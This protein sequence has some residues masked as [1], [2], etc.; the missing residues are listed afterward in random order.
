MPLGIR[1]P[2]LPC[3]IFPQLSGDEQQRAKRLY[4]HPVHMFP[5]YENY[6]SYQEHDVE[7]QA[8]LQREKEAG[9]LIMN[10]TR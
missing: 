8:E 1:H 10:E 2:I 7:A 4:A 3:G 6:T 9:Y 5:D